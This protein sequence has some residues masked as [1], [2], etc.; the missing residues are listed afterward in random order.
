MAIATV[1]DITERRQLAEEL[2]RAQ[3]MEA[4]G[5]LAGGIAHEINTPTQF[6]SDNLSFLGDSWGPVLKPLW[7]GL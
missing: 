6:I 4:L 5:H 2:Q 7:K 3:Q 1:E